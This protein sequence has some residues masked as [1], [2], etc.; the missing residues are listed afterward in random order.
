[1]PSRSPLRGFTLIELLV[2]IAILV[3]LLALLLP[4]VQKV[5]EAAA[6]MQCSNHLKQIGLALQLAAD[7]N[8]GLLPP[9]IGYYPGN[10][11]YGIGLFHLLPYLDQGNLY[12][13]AE[14]GG[15]YYPTHNGVSR[16]SL[17][18]FC[19]PSDPS[20]N[21]KDPVKDLANQE[22]GAGCYAGNAQVFAQ[23]DGRGVFTDGNG[24]ARFPG[25]FSDGT[26]NTITFA[27]KYARCTNYAVPEGGSFWAYSELGHGVQPLHAAFEVSWTFYSIGPASRFLIRPTPHNSDCDPFR[28]STAHS[29]MLV[30]LADGSVRSVSDGVSGET[31][32]A[33]CT[34]RG[35]TMLGNDW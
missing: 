9:G 27:E 22:W 6:R 26:S 12:N 20:H 29:A 31:W 3:I 13:Q 35:G 7:S 19:C 32:W 28:A 16:Y 4:A 21:G 10:S 5:R 17:E 23:V 33:A 25:S 1:M 34:P 15:F 18:V 24:K 14:I 30:V 11:A 8:E 2:V